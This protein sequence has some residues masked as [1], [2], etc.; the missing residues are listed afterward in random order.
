MNVSCNVQVIL[1][2]TSDN[3]QER[4]DQQ[5]ALKGLGILYK[6]GVI[7]YPGGEVI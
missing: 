6:E 7:Y 3:M 2:I 5:G 1:A 4:V